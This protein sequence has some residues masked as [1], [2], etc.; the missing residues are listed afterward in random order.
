MQEAQAIVERI[1]RISAT[2]QRLDLAVDKAHREV[3]AGQLFLA[4]TVDSFDSYLREPWV[5]VGHQS[6]QLVFER[7][8][9]RV[10]LPGQI[11]NL[12]GPIGKP[13]PLL[14]STRTLLLIAFESTPAALLMLADTVLERGGAVTL[15]LL[16][17]AQHYPV[18]ALP[19]EME[20]TRA[21]D[22]DH[23]TERDPVLRWADQVVAVAPPVFDLPAYAR[24]LDNI[25][26][27]R[28]E[29]PADYVLGLFHSPMPCGIGA[30]QACLVNLNGDETAAACVDGPA[31]DLRTV[32]LHIGGAR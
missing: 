1:R 17:R 2:L 19:D 21:E 11:I 12:I 32:K 14:P 26:E 6:N 20:V 30:C 29:P 23:W 10:Y 18:E 24:L 8:A 4:R 22:Y 9:N 15:A 31:F 25:R 13:I 7:P 28:M 5:P 27:I 3:S 16:G